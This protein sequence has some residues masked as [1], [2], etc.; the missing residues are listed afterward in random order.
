MITQVTFVP[1]IVFCKKNFTFLWDLDSD[2]YLIALDIF[3][4]SSFILVI[5]ERKFP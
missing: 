1:S 2:Y 5:W 3:L 4:A